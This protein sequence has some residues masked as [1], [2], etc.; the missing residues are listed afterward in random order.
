MTILA[1]KAGESGEWPDAYS[2]ECEKAL[3]EAQSD[4]KKAK[5]DLDRNLQ[6]VFKSYQLV[7]FPISSLKK[8][9]TEPQLTWNLNPTFGQTYLTRKV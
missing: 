3:L 8:T 5:K 2:A 6:K 4:S 9:K 1:K 7:E